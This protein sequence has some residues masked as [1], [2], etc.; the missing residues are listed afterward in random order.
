MNLYEI[1]FLHKL[2]TSKDSH[3]KSRNVNLSRFFVREPTTSGT[4]LSPTVEGSLHN[5]RLH[6]NTNILRYHHL[7]G[8][9]QP[10]T[11]TKIPSLTHSPHL[12]LIHGFKISSLNNNEL[13]ILREYQNCKAIYRNT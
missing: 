10:H 13:P 2:P 4:I 12:S 11:T 3:K 9:W 1:V 5:L 7:N 8:K 6:C